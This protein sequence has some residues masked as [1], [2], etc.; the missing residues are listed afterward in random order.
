MMSFADVI[1]SCK[2]SVEVSPLNLCRC[3]VFQFETDLTISI[4]GDENPV[5]THR[6]IIVNLVTIRIVKS[7]GT[8]DRKNDVSRSVKKKSHI[9][10]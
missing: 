4:T 5:L 8:F 7:L 3:E 6:S 2:S 9:S 10:Y 1:K